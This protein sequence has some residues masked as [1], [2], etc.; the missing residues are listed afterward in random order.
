MYKVNL[1]YITILMTMIFTLPDRALF[2]IFFFTR[3]ITVLLLQ[4]AYFYMQKVCVE[5]FLLLQE[6]GE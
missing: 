5:V 2:I 4:S 1:H 3:V 6:F